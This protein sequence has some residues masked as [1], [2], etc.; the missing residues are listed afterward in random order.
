MNDKEL[1]KLIS[2][3]IRENHLHEPSIGFTEK[4][5][6]IAY[7]ELKR[8]KRFSLQPAIL[9][10]LSLVL[11]LLTS[12]FLIPGQIGPF[13]GIDF[14]SFFDDMSAWLNMDFPIPRWD[15]FPIIV[16]SA[17]LMVLIQLVLLRRFFIR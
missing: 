9:I 1:D 6:G 7:W 4:L 2:D 15:N 17:L 14:A 13:F 8:K 3:I 16:G 10:P 5:T 11:Y 12:L